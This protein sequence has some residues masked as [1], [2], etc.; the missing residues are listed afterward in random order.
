MQPI[1]DADTHIAESEEMW[2]LFDK[3]M[4][5]ADPCC[6]RCPTTRLYGN[7][8]KTLADRRQYFSETGRQRRLPLDH[9]VGVEDPIQPQRL[10]RRLP[11]DDRCPGTTRRYGSARHRD[12]GRLPDAVSGL[13]HRRPEALDVALAR[14]YNRFMAQACAE[15]NGRHPLGGG[16]AAA[17]HRRISEGN[18]V[19]QREW[20]RRRFLPRHGR[21]LHFGQSVFF[22]G[23]SSGDGRGS[24]D[25]HSHRLENAAPSAAMFDLERNRQWSHSAFPPLHAFRD[26][27]LNQIPETVS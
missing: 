3:E 17:L 8:N 5:A 18:K 22:S 11:R 14:A 21:Q 15:S 23:V 2:T 13:S 10:S 16:S 25:L 7:W 20:R 1:I 19:G 24:A 4:T 26:L 6:F 12:S 9:A 27:V